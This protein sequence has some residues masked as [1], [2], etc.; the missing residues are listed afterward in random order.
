MLFLCRT[1]DYYRYLAELTVETEGPKAEA[2]QN[3]LEA[4]NRAMDVVKAAEEAGSSELKSTNPAR[5]GLALNFSVFYFE[6]MRDTEKACALAKDAFDTA[7]AEIDSFETDCEKD[8]TLIIQ[9]LR[10]NL[11]LWTQDQIENDE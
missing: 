1:G 5:L 7:V 8:S 10:D 2:A 4:Y 9:L 3:A 11:S 6:I